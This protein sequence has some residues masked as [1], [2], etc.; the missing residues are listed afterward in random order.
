M[1]PLLPELADFVPLHSP[2]SKAVETSPLCS[3]R[4]K[5]KRGSNCSLK[6]E[7]IGF[8]VLCLSFPFL[9]LLHFPFCFIFS[10]IFPPSLHLALYCSFFLAL[11][12]SSAY[13]F[14]NLYLLRCSP[15]YLYA[16]SLLPLLSP[17]HRLF[18]NCLHHCS[19]PSI[20]LF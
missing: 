5:E 14:F 2:S 7:G 12:F 6:T 1:S 9:I 20:S 4:L 18:L 16:Y 17:V 3:H 10:F 8:L 13:P 11:S 19:F 15:L